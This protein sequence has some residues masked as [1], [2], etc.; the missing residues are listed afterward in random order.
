MTPLSS[1]IAAEIAASGPIPFSRFMELALY[2]LEYGYYRRPH[3]PFGKS[4]DF[5]TAEQLQPVFGILIGRLLAGLR[6]ELGC[7]EF[8]VVE[9]GAGRE[10]MRD[11]LSG[12]R[13]IPMDAGRGRLPP[14]F[15][16]AVFTNE[17]FDALPVE[18]VVR[19]GGQFHDMRVTV[20]DSRFE[21][22]EGGP[23]RAEVADY[24]E[25]FHGPREEGEFAEANLASL[26]W[27]DTI[28]RSLDRGYIVTIDY[29]YTRR[30]SIRFPRGTLMSYRR[31]TALEDVL[32]EPGERDITAH[33]NFTALQE[34]GEALGL[35]TVRFET[36]ARAL[37]R[38]GES[39][40][41]ASALAAES[42]AEEQRRRLQLKTLLFGMGETFRL[43]LQKKG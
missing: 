8:T 21:W 15:A 4:G 22:I 34:H 29:G 9:L 7:K 30:E 25:R 12:F 1:L 33:V 10:E 37:M 11:A 14:G 39:D 32:A 16:G 26:A 2:D 42:P 28:T 19:R 18:A 36:L 24:L 27:M 5:F 13:Y 31:H 20:K 23:A 17:F 38:T 43:L 41:F 35:Q 6:D 40:E 3:D